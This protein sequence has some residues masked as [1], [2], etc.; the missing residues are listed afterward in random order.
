MDLKSI[1]NSFNTQT[2]PGIKS[3]KKHPSIDTEEFKTYGKLFI[4]K[5]FLNDGRKP[6]K[7]VG[8]GAKSESLS[9]PV[10]FIIYDLKMHPAVFFEFKDD[11]DMNGFFKF[12]GDFISKSK[13]KMPAKKGTKIKEDLVIEKIK[14]DGDTYVY[15]KSNEERFAQ[16]IGYI[17]GIIMI[18]SLLTIA[19]YYFK[20]IKYAAE[21]YLV[22][23]KVENEL[24]KQL[25]QGQQKN[26]SGFEIFSTLE[27]YIKL[28]LYGKINS[29]ILCGPPGMSKTYM[30]RRTLH[31]ENK[32][33]GK[34][35]VIEKGSSLGI[36]SVYQLLYENRS[37][38]IVL[39]DFDTPLQNED[40]INIM[41][42]ITDSYGKRIVSLSPEKK[43]STQGG[44]RF[45]AP[46][47][48]EFTGQV[49][50]I[51]N[52]AKNSLDIALRSRSP[53][54]EVSFN[55]KEVLAA[56][57]KLL[58]FI[59]PQV[60]YET[61]LKVFN[62]I[63]ELYKKDKYIDISFRSI[64]ATIDARVGNPDDWKEMAKLVAGYKGKEIKENLI[65]KVLVKLQ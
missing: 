8:F 38:L 25:F 40:I 18:G 32:L 63:K 39:D 21:E 44:E 9:D 61:K 2:I 54:V 22:N 65:T 28:V 31:F 47:K 19:Y 20:T 37:K 4:Q 51:T 11:F 5:Y 48:F 46:N 30:V 24:N 14:D 27:N 35:Y 17:S 6:N 3:I 45:D 60:P 53:V 7:M 52:K 1:A 10:I 55:A 26:E 23:S 56:F 43:L 36:N 49:I 15:K 29:L 64:K 33:P 58:K 59:A 50:M 57:D 16:I 34:D 13:F 62:Y 12:V 42:A 41:K